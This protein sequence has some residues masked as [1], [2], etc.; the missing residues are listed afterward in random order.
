MSNETITV[1]FFAAAEQ[2]A[3][4]DELEVALADLPTQVDGP[5]L[6]HLISYLGAENLELAHVMAHCAFLANATR[7]KASDSLV[8]IK[9]LEVLP[10]FAGG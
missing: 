9:A 1:R 7:L 6:E 2:A 8:G 4:T 3:H 10:P 5:Q